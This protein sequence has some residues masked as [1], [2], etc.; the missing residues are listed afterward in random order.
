QH[1]TGQDDGQSKAD[2]GIEHSTHRTNQRSHASNQ[3]H[4]SLSRAATLGIAT[5]KP[6][7]L[8]MLG[9]LAFGTMLSL[10]RS[11][12]GVTLNHPWPFEYCFGV[13]TYNISEGLFRGNINPSTSVRRLCTFA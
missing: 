11:T 5:I 4:T 3:R 10:R 8:V 9:R 7:S 1:C 13:R 2:P 12:T 6:R